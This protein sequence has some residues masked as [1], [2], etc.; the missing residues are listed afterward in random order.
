MIWGTNKPGTW[1]TA[2]YE[3]IAESGNIVKDGFLDSGGGTTQ[4][5][6]DFGQSVASLGDLMANTGYTVNGFV[7]R[8]GL[9]WKMIG[10]RSEQ[11]I[12][13][14]NGDLQNGGPNGTLYGR[15]ISMIDNGSWD[16]AKAQLIA[17]DMTKAV[18]GM[19]QD[20]TFK[21]F[22]EGVISDDNGVVILNLMQQDAVAMRL[23][24]R[25]A[26]AVANPVTIMQPSQ[27]I[28]GAANTVMRWP[29][30]AIAT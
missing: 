5:A 12:P 25:L 16:A 24:M 9:D 7:G 1:G 20:M 6:A 26:Y 28:D 30:G 15:R 13:I 3:G 23:V 17:G 4:A 29:F 2:L 18:I 8:P 11:G 14:Y 10:L 19:R 22:T 21:M 27:T